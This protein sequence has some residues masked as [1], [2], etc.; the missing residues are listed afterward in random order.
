[1]N[2]ESITQRIESLKREG[3]ELR[4]PGGKNRASPDDR[5]YA[6]FGVIPRKRIHKEYG[7]KDVIWYEVLLIPYNNKLGNSQDEE[8]D[9]EEKSFAETPD[10]TLEREIGEET[11]VLLKKY[12]LL[13]S[14]SI[15]DNRSEDNLTHDKYAYISTIYDAS[16][17]R[18]TLS[19]FQP[20]LGLP[21]SVPLDLA[22]QEIFPHHRWILEETKVYLEHIGHLL[23]FYKKTH[24]KGKRRFQHR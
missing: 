3:Y 22:I 5:S 8:G 2:T 14:K 13:K 12:E 24:R 17:I 19:L 23:P 7:K 16:N 21:I 18:R 6:C 1:M 4:V 11:G 15:L 9:F 20:K 10:G